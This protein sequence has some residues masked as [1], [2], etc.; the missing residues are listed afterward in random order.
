MSGALAYLPIP[1]FGPTASCPLAGGIPDGQ[2]FLVD[3]RPGLEPLPLLHGGQLVV[4]LG[5]AAPHHDVQ[6]AVALRGQERQEAVHTAER[7]HGRGD[8]KRHGGH[9]AE[10]RYKQYIVVMEMLP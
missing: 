2:V 7:V 10:V 5:A 1:S 8:S 4:P 9:E 3:G 6:P